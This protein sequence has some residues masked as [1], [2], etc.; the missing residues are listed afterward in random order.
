MNKI[1]DE[2]VV[3][4]KINYIMIC[5]QISKGSGKEGPKRETVKENKKRI[6][7]KNSTSSYEG[8]K[9]YVIWLLIQIL[10]TFIY[11]NNNWHH[12]HHTLIRTGVFFPTKLLLSI[13]T[14]A[15]DCN[16]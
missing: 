7:I 12:L 6:Q 14:L 2:R 11:T 5:L 8:T 13:K 10:L 1:I 16:R 3:M 9:K 15:G 4:H